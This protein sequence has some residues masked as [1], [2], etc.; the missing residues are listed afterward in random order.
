MRNREILDI[1]E[2]S[3]ERVARSRVK[4]NAKEETT[5][6]EQESESGY[7]EA[8]QALDIEMRSG[9]LSS[10]KKSKT[11]QNLAENT[12]RLVAYRTITIR[13]KD[14]LIVYTGLMKEN[15][16]RAQKLLTEIL[17]L[18]IVEMY[19]FNKILGKIDEKLDTTQVSEEF[20][21]FLI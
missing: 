3:N 2:I 18:R 8:Q 6:N 4:Q 9:D 14:L 11:F 5:E 21:I 12:K 7:S 19:L 1:A 10:L 15:P 13:L 16:H 17:L 20:K